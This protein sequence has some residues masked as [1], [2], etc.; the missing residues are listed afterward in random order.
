MCESGGNG[1][2]NRK[3]K[4][5]L[6]ERIL[7]ISMDPPMERPTVLELIDKYSLG[8]LKEEL[9]RREKEEKTNGNH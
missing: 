5:I 8:Q 3:A 1:M 7:N 6:A 4:T 2:N 9:K